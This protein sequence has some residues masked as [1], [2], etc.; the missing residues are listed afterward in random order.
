MD[1]KSEKILSVAFDLFMR[2][3]FKKVTM[4]DI[5]EAADMSRPTLYASFPN[6]EAVFAGLGQRQC[7]RA[8]DEISARLP[9]AR[10]LE[11]KLRVVLD[12]II[13][14]P[15]SSIMSS[16]HGLE[17][18]ANAG[19][20][21]PEQTNEVYRRLERQ[22]VAVLAPAIG[23]K[24]AMPASDLAHIITMASRGLKASSTTPEELRRLVDGLIA[25]AVISA[26]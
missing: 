12:V 10:T 18:L 3:G 25:M 7:G 26:G 22:L 19:A 4:S 16:P 1:A 11:A 21:A 5:A 14:E 6:K 2:H 20:Y 9:K 13:V 17:L 23:K 15:A 24:A 8:D